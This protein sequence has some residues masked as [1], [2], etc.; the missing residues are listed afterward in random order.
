VRAGDRDFSGDT[1]TSL[2][3][4]GVQSLETGGYVASA[5]PNRDALLIRGDERRVIG[6][7]GLRCG[8][9]TRLPS[10]YLSA[11]G[12][13]LVGDAKL[14]K[15]PNFAP[16]NR[17]DPQHRHLNLLH[18]LLDNYVTAWQT[19]IV[20][21]GISYAARPGG[22]GTLP[23]TGPGEGLALAISTRAR[24]TGPSWRTAADGAR[25]MVA[26]ILT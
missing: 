14:T 19:E 25:R 22:Q 10:H 13:C 5:R 17:A 21:P 15:R 24:S 12:R 1:P 3:Q 11:R 26:A 23:H 8:A 9:P 18:S 16:W 7:C 2:A 20:E 6:A 4:A